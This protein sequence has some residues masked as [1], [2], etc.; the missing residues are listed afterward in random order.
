MSE[1]MQPRR[2]GVT[3]HSNEQIINALMLRHMINEWKRIS[4]CCNTGNHYT[5]V[6]F[7]VSE[8]N[9]MHH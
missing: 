7:A 9:F 5:D 2:N 8:T 3:E 4:V 6:N 1:Q